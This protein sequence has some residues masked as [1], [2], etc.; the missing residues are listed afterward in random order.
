MP[1]NQRWRTQAYIVPSLPAS[2]RLF[3]LRLKS[4]FRGVELLKV[5]VNRESPLVGLGPLVSHTRRSTYRHSRLFLTKRLGMQHDLLSDRHVSVDNY[6][7]YPLLAVPM[8]SNMS[9]TDFPQHGPFR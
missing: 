6:L 8:L 1:E 9:P 4:S 2:N 7:L 3:Y 5:P